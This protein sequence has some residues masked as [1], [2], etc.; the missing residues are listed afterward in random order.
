MRTNFN[1]RQ[2]NTGG[3]NP[4]RTILDEQY[5]TVPEAAKLVGVHAASIRRWIDSGQ[6]PAHRV[7]RRRVLIKRADL[8]KLITPARSEQEKGG[9]MSRAES[10]QVSSLSREEQVKL[11]QAVEAAKRAQQEQLARRA[12]KPF[13]SSDT[14]IN[15]LRDERSRELQ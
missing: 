1:F 12:G 15:E 9:A 13:P 4:M 14:L 10:L 11:L 7:G 6:L 2:Q 8:A 5:V 3:G